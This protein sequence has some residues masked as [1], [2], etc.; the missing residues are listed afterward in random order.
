MH[1]YSSNRLCHPN[2][3]KHNLKYKKTCWNSYIFFKHSLDVFSTVFFHRCLVSYFLT[4]TRFYFIPLTLYNTR[5]KSVSF[6]AP[7]SQPTI[8][9]VFISIQYTSRQQRD[10][11]HSTSGFILQHTNSIAH[12]T[13]YISQFNTTC[14]WW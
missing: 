6:L 2:S 10:D 12:N 3:H 7:K 13:I 11:I 14:R 1:T 5:Y 8:R 9:V 4:Y